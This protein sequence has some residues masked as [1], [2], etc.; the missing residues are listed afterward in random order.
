MTKEIQIFK[1]PDDEVNDDD[2]SKYERL[3][4]KMI[5][6]HRPWTNIVETYSLELDRVIMLLLNQKDN[7]ITK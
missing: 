6:I 1:N 5:K 7:N 4:V 2:Y 3:C